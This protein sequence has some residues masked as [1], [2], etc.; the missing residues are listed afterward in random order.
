MT[1]PDNS[2]SIL[3]LHS[4]RSFLAVAQTGS[5]T[6]A[7]DRV[8]LS[9]SAAS[10]QI[11][12]L[13]EQLGCELLVRGPRGVTLTVHGEA[14]VT[15]ARRMLEL[16]RE[17][18]GLIVGKNTTNPIRIGCPYEVVLPLASRAIRTFKQQSERSIRLY[19]ASSL[20][21]R[22]AFERNELDLALTM[23][24]I[25]VADARTIASRELIWVTAPQSLLGFANPLPV[26]FEASSVVRAIALA[27][28]SSSHLPHRVIENASD[29]IA[30][31][32]SVA[33]DEGVSALIADQCPDFLVQ[34]PAEWKLPQ[35]PRL[36]INLSISDP[37]SQDLGHL[38]EQFVV[39]FSQVDHS[40]SATNLRVP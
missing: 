20:L 29:P 4:L 34:A 12:R 11:R 32:A 5:I 18:V 37:M 2:R 8:S 40:N 35:L 28:L 6:A 10:L 13:E 15:Y 9:Q 17:V 19:C 30:V 38:A 16:N 27:S 1:L 3:D 7:A 26:V 31:L 24:A 23:D 33:A 25:S 36:M 21:V 22:Q 39:S 14:L